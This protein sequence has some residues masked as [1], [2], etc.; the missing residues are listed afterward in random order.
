MRAPRP[1]PRPSPRRPA[2]GRATLWLSR[3]P[4]ACPTAVPR[5]RPR[6]RDSRSGKSASRI[7]GCSAKRRP[8]NA[9]R[10]AHD[11]R[12]SASPAV[13]IEG[14]GALEIVHRERDHAEA[15]LHAHTRLS[16][17]TATSRTA[18]YTTHCSG[19]L[20][21]LCRDRGQRLRVAEPPESDAFLRHR[22]SRTWRR[23]RRRVPGPR[24]R[25]YSHRGGG[26]GKRD[27]NRARIFI[28]DLRTN[29]PTA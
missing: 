29:Q 6:P 19:P 23:S 14:D 26:A 27:A 20:P 15:R 7:P 8:P 1:Q 21:R 28:F 22:R 18:H 24:R 13:A 10:T 17:T 11:A 12:A 3:Q 16:G 4:L 9:V 5:R 2:R 25:Q